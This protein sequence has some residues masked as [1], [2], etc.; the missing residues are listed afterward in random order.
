[1]RCPVCECTNSRV[2]E[3]RSNEDHSTIRRRRECVGC[4][5]RF[6]TY[7]TVERTPLMVI[8]KD[9]RREPFQRDKLL[10][11]VLRAVE[12]RPIDLQTLEDLVDQVEREIRTEF[13]REVPSEQLGEKVIV[14][15]REI[16]GVAYVRF[17]SVYREF[18]D[19][20]TFAKEL[21][22]LLNS[23]SG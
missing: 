1:M 11:G 3:S 21:M 6:T 7:E 22:S 23:P 5:R 17:A 14:R 2:L 8:K 13:D 20:E 15:L 19:V 16:D 4:G 18:R 9:K 10:R 12:K